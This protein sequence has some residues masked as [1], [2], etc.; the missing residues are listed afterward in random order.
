MPRFRSNHRQRGGDNGKAGAG[1]AE[2]QQRV[3]NIKLPR[4]GDLADH[5]ARSRRH[6]NAAEQAGAR[7]RRPHRLADKGDDDRAEQI[8]ECRRC[9]NQRGRPAVQPMQLGEVNALAVK[10]EGP[11]EGRYQK[12]HRDDPPAFITG[13]GFDDGDVTGCVQRL[14]LLF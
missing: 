14:S 11:A 2:C 4:R 12:A 10:P 9:R 1:P 3:R 7:A 8:E 13:G 5:D 6:D